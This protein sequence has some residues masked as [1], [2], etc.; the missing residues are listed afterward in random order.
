MPQQ[1]VNFFSPGVIIDDIPAKIFL[2]LEKEINK[3]QKDFESAEAV[4]DTLVG[5]IK[6]EY[7]LTDCH[8]L[9]DE[10]LQHLL[11][12][13]NNNNAQWLSFAPVVKEDTSYVL[14]QL[15][16]NFQEKYEFNPP[17]DHSGVMSFV[18][19]MKI[20]YSIENE[21][22]QYSNARHGSQA[23]KFGFLYTDTLGKISEI[24]LPVDKTW[25]GKIALFPASM[26]HYVNPFYTSDDYRI[27]VSG[28]IKLSTTTT[29]YQL[30]TRN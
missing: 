25:Q 21:S 3:I 17:H 14:D 20:P 18:I 28:N 2:P 15:W 22:K 13:Y 4:N 30:G 1:K 24:T 11:Q 19:W 23:G 29:Q 9:I 10:Y 26:Y 7:K 6:K 12:D 27:S 5:Q 16:V 8:S